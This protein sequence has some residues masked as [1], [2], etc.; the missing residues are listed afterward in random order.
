MSSSD[1]QTANRRAEKGDFKKLIICIG[2]QG[3]LW[4]LLFTSQLLC[5]LSNEEYFPENVQIELE[6]H[7]LTIKFQVDLRWLPK[8]LPFSNRPVEKG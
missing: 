8:L 5:I 1:R 3:I 2:A 4:L 7:N 6:A